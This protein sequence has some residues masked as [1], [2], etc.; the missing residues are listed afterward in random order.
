MKYNFL[1][2][3][4]EFKNGYIAYSDLFTINKECYNINIG[5]KI[6]CDDKRYL[7]KDINIVFKQGSL[8]TFQKEVNVY[9][10]EI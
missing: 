9:V 6:I 3:E 1:L 10:K 4:Q 8:V 2:I 5:N 7:I